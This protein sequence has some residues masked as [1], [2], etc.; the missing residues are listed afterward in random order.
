MTNAPQSLLDVRDFFQTIN[1]RLTDNQLGIVGGPSH[2]A[3]GTSYHLGKDQ[4]KMSKNPYSARTARDK[5]GL[6][7]ASIA[8]YANAFDLDKAIGD[9][10][11]LST[12]CVNECRRG[13]P[14]TL[15]MREIIYSPDGKT[16][17]TWD[18]EKGT[19]STPEHRGGLEHLLHTHFSWYRD[20]ALRNKVA[21]FQ[22]YYAKVIDMFFLRVPGNPAV[23]VSDGIN[24]R[25]VPAG[26]WG[27][28]C[29]PLMKAG[30]PMLDY[31]SFTALLDGGGPLVKETTPGELP[32]KVT[33]SIPAH[34][35]EIGLE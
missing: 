20:A 3:T 19:S 21:L 12:W 27:L 10:P 18:R 5:A 30:V 7:T 28:T 26:Q 1:P 32:E 16:V 15:D 11:I 33:V 23:Y 29:E 13:A 22:R 34:K 14:D 17:W 8:N 2:I 35:L 9:L 6:A 24:T 25:A 4:L 31:P